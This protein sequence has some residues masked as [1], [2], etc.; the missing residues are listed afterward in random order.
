MAFSGAQGAMLIE[1]VATSNPNQPIVIVV[2]SAG[3]RK[4]CFDCSLE[5]M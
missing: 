1:Q 3:L 4:H 5:L 2:D